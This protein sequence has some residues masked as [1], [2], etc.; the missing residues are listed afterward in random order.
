MSTYTVTAFAASSSLSGET[1]MT[2]KTDNKVNLDA[3]GTLPDVIADKQKYT[4]TTLKIAGP[5]NGTDIGFIH[6]LYTGA[7]YSGGTQ[8][9][10]FTTSS[11]VTTVG[12]TSGMGGGGGT[13]G[14]WR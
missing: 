7:T 5:I 3:A 2:V 14:G 6:G 9:S 4:I 8:A 13:P 1:S 12:S 11:T 10:T